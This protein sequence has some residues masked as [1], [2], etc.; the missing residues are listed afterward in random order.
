MAKIWEKHKGYLPAL[1][2]VIFTTRTCFRSIHIEGAERIPQDGAVIL[3]PNHCAALMDPLL[4]LVL[5]GGKPVV[6]GARSDIF[7]NPK[8]AKVLR[9]L[10]ILP[11]ARER[12]GLSEVAKNFDTFQEIIDCLDHEVPFCLYA[13]GTH[14]PE[15]EMLPVKKGIFRVARM[16]QDQLGVPV[17]IVPI[18]V[19]YE[20]FFRG[21]GRISIR[22]GEPM[23][24]GEEFAKRAG[25]AE[26]D[27]YREL[28]TELRD[29][30]MALIGPER[31]RRHDRKLLRALGALLSLPLFAVCAVGSLLIWLPYAIIMHGM[32]DK[33]WSHTVRFVM[34][35]IFP[36]LWI[37]HIPFERL[38]NFYRHLFE[39]LK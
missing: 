38:L 30:D 29:R 34:H 26:A 12:N 18:G 24:I 11:I 8:V 31:T 23:E 19:N 27:I 5:F 10:R 3:A 9:W 37:F 17:R 7:A 4:T 2:Y 28:C 1:K 36:V 14:N 22:V 21:Q 15:R 33:A 35:F 16:A 6:F 39:D 13:E 32:E 25:L 20:D